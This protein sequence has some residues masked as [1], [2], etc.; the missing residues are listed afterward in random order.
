[1][2]DV[3]IVIYPYNTGGET[4]ATVLNLVYLYFGI[5]NPGK[6]AWP[7]PWPPGGLGPQDPSKKLAYWVDLL[8][9]P[10][11]RKQQ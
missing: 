6:W 8:G 1:M 9:Q 4:G 7:P 5:M 2:S 3:G 11:T 10:L